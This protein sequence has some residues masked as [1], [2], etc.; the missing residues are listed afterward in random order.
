MYVIKDA[1]WGASADGA[2]QKFRDLVGND[3]DRDPSQEQID[4]LMYYNVGNLMCIP[5]MSLLPGEAPY[6]HW[7]ES[8]QDSQ[9][10][11]VKWRQNQWK[12][13]IYGKYA[14]MDKIWEN[15]RPY[16]P[17]MQQ[18]TQ[19]WIDENPHVQEYIDEWCRPDVLH[20]H[21]RCG[22]IGALDP[23][24][25]GYLE[26]A[27]VRSQASELLL[28]AGVHSNWENLPRQNA[29]NNA[30]PGTIDGVWN[31]S[32]AAIRALAERFPTIK[33]VLCS[34]DETMAAWM[35]AKHF[36]MHQGSFS[37]TGW[38]LNKHMTYVSIPGCHHYIRCTESKKPHKVEG[39]TYTWLS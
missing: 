7:C 22:D 13:T 36:M 17:E 23:F 9:W 16:I 39:K 10:R 25:I 38:C 28:Y 35:H 6:G 12:G 4:R 21:M 31:N 11:Q 1:A 5:C 32:A 3:E 27:L 33:F 2:R 18:C 26:K 15:D 20:A 29:S 14:D 37:V 19:E 8:S 34:V 24:I 30:M